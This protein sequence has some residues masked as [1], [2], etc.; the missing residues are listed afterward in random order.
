MIKIQNTKKKY[1]LA[2]EIFIII[3]AAIAVT[4]TILDL[5]SMIVLLKG[6]FLYWVEFGILVIFII[7]YF[8]RL[9]FSK[10]KGKFVK[11]N[12]F[13]LISII[14]FNSMFRI[15]RAFRIFRVLKISKVFRI[16][17][18]TRL[19]KA[20]ALLGRLKERLNTFI[21]TNGFIY[22]IYITIIT[23]IIST[24]G[25]Y[26]IEF[27]TKNIAFSECLWWSF[28]TTTTVGYG[29]IDPETFAARM[30]AAVL[31]LVGIGFTGMLTGTIATYFL[32]TKNFKNEDI[33][34]ENFIDI[35]DLEDDKVAQITDY[36]E[37]IR[38]KK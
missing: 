7:D 22:T 17:K 13:D 30:I 37:F 21:N 14:P 8:T 15:F 28:A 23:V 25:V 16:T 2:Y 36:I 27:K 5:T 33:I 9:L 6:S 3:L 4:I 35:S 38:N 19:V 32:N 11:N 20:F 12:M 26:F 1:S 31:M 29:G 18:M 34:K 24:I 10:E